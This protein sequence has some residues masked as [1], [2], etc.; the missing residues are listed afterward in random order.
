MTAVHEPGL[1]E[2]YGDWGLGLIRT[3]CLAVAVL[4]HIAVRQIF[5]PA[6][7]SPPFHLDYLEAAPSGT[8]LMRPSP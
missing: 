3:Q 2:G 6:I 1:K 4:R 8:F 5:S 7:T